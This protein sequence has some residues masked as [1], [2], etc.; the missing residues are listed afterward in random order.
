MSLVSDRLQI[1]FGLLWFEEKS[2]NLADSNLANC[3]ASKISNCR[4]RT[5]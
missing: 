1:H 3:L 2:E 4:T 5:S